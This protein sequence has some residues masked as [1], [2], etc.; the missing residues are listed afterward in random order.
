MV[1]WVRVLLV[2]EG[3]A[4]EVCELPNNLKALEL[5]VR[6]YIETI[7]IDRSGCVIIY[8][9]INKFTE[10]PVTRAEIKGTFIIARVNPPEL[11]SLNNEDIEILA[12][13][14]K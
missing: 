5:T 12:N 11:S 9:G 7:E 2:K 10:K 4:P 8:N 6:G 1:K 13:S 3:K 14:Y